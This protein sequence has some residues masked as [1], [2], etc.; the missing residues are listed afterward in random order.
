MQTHRFLFL[1]L[2]FL[3]GGTFAA[4]PVAVPR[5][6]VHELTLRATG[7][8]AN[9]YTEAG[10]TATFTGPGGQ[11]KTVA[12]FW[13]DANTFKI[14]FTP[15]AE[16][17]WTY[18][19]RSTD[20]GL[21]GKRGEITCTAPTPGT[22]GF[23]RRDPAHP[24]HFIHDDGTRYFL[25]GTTYYGLVSAALAGEGW[26][27]A[28][29]SC[30]RYGITKIRFRVNVKICENA[31]S[32]NPCSSVYGADHDH[33]NPAHL[34]AVDR[35]VQYLGERGIA[36]DFLVFDSQEKFYG[37][38]AQDLRYLRHVLA[39]YA[40]YP[41]VFWCLTNEFQR[42]PNKPREFWNTAGTLVQAEDPY[43]ADGE[44]RRL[45]S[46]HPFGGQ[47]NGAQFQFHDE[48]WPTHAILQA[49]RF[50][51]A[52]TLNLITLRNRGHQR[53]IVNDEFGYFD[54]DIREWG[55]GG[56]TR[57]VHRNALWGTYLAGGYATVG[58]KAQY[59][60]GRPYQSTA[61]HS[62]PEYADLKHLSDFFTKKELPYW[63][64][65][66]AN[67]LI[68]SGERAYALRTGDGATGVLY[69]AAGGTL[70]VLLP[71]GQYAAR[72]YDPRTG[73]E[74]PL[75]DWTGGQPLTL[76]LPDAQDW[77]LYFRRTGTAAAQQVS[78]SVKD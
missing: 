71:Y 3:A 13:D 72:R 43:F 64:M 38:D 16:G 10:V 74:V 35:V 30:A 21:N 49:G 73:T 2:V 8:Y 31:V 42:V 63:A 27:A 19:T 66:P 34:R 65:V 57:A 50:V 25:L 76:T 59:P 32:P 22:H 17:R 46:I 11:Q 9:P 15:T 61:W 77:V 23:I 67:E 60:D 54:D 69:A 29:D 58:D 78:R 1:L 53:P 45:L 36:A 33:L 20:A 40:A 26:K 55:N 4:P 62:R 52:D 12:G 70:Q 6:S 48:P 5:W 68:A 28:V 44:R 47:S 56:Y 39:R 18:L 24:Y 37:T 75:A 7:R 14:R 41:N 51:P